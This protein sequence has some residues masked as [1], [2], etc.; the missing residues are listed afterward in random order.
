MTTTAIAL[1]RP[2]RMWRQVRRR[3]LGALG[4]VVTAIVVLAAV[5][6][7]WLAPYDPNRQSLGD[8][9]EP[10]RA[11]HWLG[12][13]ELGRDVLSRVLYGG[14]VSLLIG[15]GSV[16]AGL[17][18]GA[19]LGIVAGYRG[20]W[21]DSLI[22]RGVE[23]PLVFSGFLMAV[24][25]LAILGQGVVNVVI[26][27]GLRSLPIFARIARN[28]TLSLRERTYVEAAVA[29]GSGELAIL[30]RH[31]L[32]NLVSPLLVVATLRTGAAIL[33]AASLS[34]LGLGVP[35]QIPEWGTMI[36]NGMAYLR[37][38]AHH[39]VLAPGLAIMAAVL[40]LNLLGDD[41]R[42][43]WDPRQRD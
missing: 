5:L 40:G 18:V 25:V 35:P 1:P 32:P 43:A 9:L 23:V 26:A 10:P 4:L 29:A 33:L 37:T 22:M 7:P 14:R 38:G 24:W 36:K 30:R 13:D 2:R 3:W 6:A 41:L 19:P 28:T 27:L 31:I 34:F 21:A 42:D 39:L 11:G 12:N 15:I 17:M 8:A 16:V 20:G